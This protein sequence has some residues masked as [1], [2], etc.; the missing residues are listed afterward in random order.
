MY[1]RS[2][3]KRPPGAGTDTPGATPGSIQSRSRDKYTLL[4]PHFEMIFL[5]VAFMP[6]S[7]ISKGVIISK[8]CFVA[9]RNSSN[10]AALVPMRRLFLQLI[11]SDASVITDP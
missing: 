5:A 11:Y 7:V 6:N 8:P 1:I 2:R 3:G 4:D 10:S 9:F